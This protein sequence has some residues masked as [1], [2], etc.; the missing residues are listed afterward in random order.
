MQRD[1]DGK[2]YKFVG[3]SRVDAKGIVQ[4]GLDLE[5]IINLKM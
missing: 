3:I 2:F 4:A 5:N 1:I